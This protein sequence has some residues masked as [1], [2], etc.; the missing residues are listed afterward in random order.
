MSHTHFKLQSF[1]DPISALLKK[2]LALTRFNSKFVT[3]MIV[4]D[5]ERDHSMGSPMDGTP[6]GMRT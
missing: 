6:H 3:V 4:N 1:V 2:Q 5:S